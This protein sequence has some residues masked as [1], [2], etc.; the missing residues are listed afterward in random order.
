VYFVRLYPAKYN[1]AAEWFKPEA[2]GEVAELQITGAYTA[3]VRF[4]VIQLRKRNTPHR[5]TLNRRRKSVSVNASK[6][7]QKSKCIGVYI[8]ISKL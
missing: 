4:C 2:Y 3:N 1:T 8:D 6:C 7:L 5:L